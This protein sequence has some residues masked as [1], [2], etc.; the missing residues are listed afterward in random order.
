MT[1]TA[2]ISIAAVMIISE[3][4]LDSYAFEVFLRHAHEQETEELLVR[5]CQSVEIFV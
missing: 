3:V 2:M 5:H 1:V 4:M